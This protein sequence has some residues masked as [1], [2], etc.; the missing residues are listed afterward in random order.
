[1]AIQK[2]FMIWVV[3][4]L[5]KTFSSNAVTAATADDSYAATDIGTS[6][7]AAGEHI[8]VA[9]F[10]DSANNGTKTLV[11]VGAN[12]VTVEENLADEAPGDSIVIDEFYYGEWRPI[13]DFSYLTGTINCD[14][15][16]T[17]YIDQSRDGVNVDNTNSF[18]VTGGTGESWKYAVVVSGY[19]RVRI[20]NGGTSQTAMRCI[21]NGAN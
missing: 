20:L 19:A 14:Q 13:R 11:T 1:M 8:S 9:G 5:L 18:S 10:S 17:V 2:T 12:K 21:L 4:H 6:T 3:E 7:F 16:C 15:N